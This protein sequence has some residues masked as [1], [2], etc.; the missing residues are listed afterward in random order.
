[1][2]LRTKTRMK[3]C[4]LIL[5]T[6]LF[7]LAYGSKTGQAAPAPTGP[8]ADFEKG[9]YSCHNVGGGDKKGPDLKGVTDRRTKE[10][11]REYIAT[12]QAMYRK[13]DPTT[14]ELFKKFSP[15]VMPDQ[16]L[17]PEQIDGILNFI[18]SLTRKNEQFVPAGAKLSRPMIA[19]DFG[20][21]MLLFA[22][23]TPLKNGGFAC[24]SCHT[25]NG[26]GTLGGG[27]LGP[28]LT[29]AN[30]KY[31]DPELISILQNPNFPTMSSVFASHPL[32]D[33][34]IVKL[35]AVFQGN[36]QGAL[37]TQVPTQVDLKFPLI[38]IGLLVVFLVITNAI[39][40]NRHR[41]VREE[42]VQRM[43]RS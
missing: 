5:C 41:G 43:R 3:W 17:S 8:A 22:G 27:T 21:G 16:A 6:F 15:E 30:V 18:E 29:I 23:K 14:V 19:T 31:K 36:R 1:M 34:E 9:C 42:L 35:F 32:T 4:W 39:W 28:N 24:V 7:C 26:I 20:D 38:G 40:K 33:D 2:M 13:N 37:A 10:W 11:L 25:I 12:P